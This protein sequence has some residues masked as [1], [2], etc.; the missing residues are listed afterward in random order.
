[1]SLVSFKCSRRNYELC[2]KIINIFGGTFIM[3]KTAKGNKKTYVHSYTKSN[4]TKIRNHYRSN[5]KTS[6]GKKN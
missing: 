1:M 2:A 5:P 3:A 6:K 4:G